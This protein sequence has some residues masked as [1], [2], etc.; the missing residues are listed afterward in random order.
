MKSDSLP[1]CPEPVEGAT[2]N[3]KNIWHGG[4]AIWSNSPGFQAV[5]I[6]RRDV[7]SFLIISMTFAS[8]STVAIGP[9]PVEGSGFCQLLHCTP[10]TRPKSPGNFAFGAQYGASA[11]SVQIVRSLP[12]SSLRRLSSPEPSINHSSSLFTALNASFFVVT[13]GKP[14]SISALAVRTFVQDFL[15]EVI[16]LAHIFPQCTT[17][18]ARGTI[19]FS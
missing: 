12:L 19:L 10:Y 14:F 4:S 7:G 16:V 17:A 3:W 18:E 6:K 9:E 1:A 15:Q 2:K 11:L 5:T 13:A 8:W